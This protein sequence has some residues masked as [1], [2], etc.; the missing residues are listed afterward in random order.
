MRSGRALLVLL[1]VV[2]VVFPL[3]R[4]STVQH[5]QDKYGFVLTLEYA[6][7][8][9]AGLRGILSQQCWISSF[10]FP[11]VIVEPFSNNSYLQHS[12]H[13]WKRTNPFARL[14]DLFDLNH[15]N[16]QSHLEGNTSIATWEHFIDSAPRKLI[17][18]TIEDI[19]HSGCLFFKSEMCETETNVSNT[20]FFAGCNASISEETLSYLQKHNFYVVRS[21]CLNCMEAMAHLTPDAI[22]DHIFGPHNAK[23]VTLVFN[24]WKFSVQIT[25][26]CREVETCIS[27]KILPMRV[28]NSD[29]LERDAIWYR[30]SYLHSQKV[31]SIMIRVE[32]HIITHRNDEKNN[33]TIKCFGEVLQAVNEIQHGLGNVSVSPFLSTDVGVF[34][35]GSFEKTKRLTK[36]RESTYSAVLNHTRHFVKELYRNTWTLRDWE[37]SFLTIPGLLINTGYISSL[38]RT[39][40]SKGDCLILMGGGYFQYMALQSYLSLHPTPSEQCVKHVCVAPIFQ[41]LFRT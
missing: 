3:Q 11:L 1:I 38:Q 17:L 18:V 39:I 22:T 37:E 13:I 27:K 19:Q 14:S 24:T 33:A 26:Q 12:H 36:T 30:E 40:A 5:S 4:W 9:M 8:L 28:I 15:F 25:K 20:E 29:R 41:R 16:E 6:G 34:G 10:G 23:D 35:S 21:V 2:V 31:I 7:Q 32:W